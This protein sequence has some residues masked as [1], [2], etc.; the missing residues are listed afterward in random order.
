MIPCRYCGRPGVIVTA[1]RARVGVSGGKLVA[2]IL[3]LGFS[4]FLVGLSRHEKV[5]H[6]RCTHCGLTW[7][8]RR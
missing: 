7:T 8:D 2:F 6:F 3:T 4:I 5:N 1:G